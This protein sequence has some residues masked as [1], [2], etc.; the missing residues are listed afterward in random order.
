MIV[1]YT[2]LALAILASG[3][4][5]QASAAAFD[6]CP[7]EAFLVQGTSSVAYGVNL[8]TG[9]YH[10]LPEDGIVK[11]IISGAGKGNG[12]GYSFHD[13]HIYGWT[14]ADDTVFKM[15]DDYVAEPLTLKN[16]GLLST[17]FYIGDV[18]PYVQGDSPEET[19]TDNA[20]YMY[21][22]GNSH[23]LYRVEL[24]P[25]KGDDYLRITRIISGGQLNY[26][27]YDF[28][29]HPTNGFLYSVDK[30]G[31]LVKINASDGSSEVLGNVGQSG[32]F[33]A[34]YFDSDGNLYISRNQD[35]NIYRVNVTSDTPVAEFFAFGPSS[36][37]NDGARCA[38]ADVPISEDTVDEGDAPST[39]D[40]GEGGGDVGAVHGKVDGIQLG[41]TLGGP[42]D[43][44]TFITGFETGQPALVS[45][46]AQGEKTLTAWID[47]DQNGSFDDDEIVFDNLELSE[48]STTAVIDVPTDAVVG[49][50]W[51]R[52]RYSPA[53]TTSPTGGA[54]DGEV[55]DYELTVTESGVGIISYPG[56]NSFVS[57]AFEDNWPHQGDYD[58]NDV[59]MSFQTEK[60]VDATSSVVRYVMSGSLLAV[61]ASYH[62]GFAVL[63]DGIATNNIETDRVVLTINGELVDSATF[64]PLEQNAPTDDAVLIIT[65]DLWQ[66]V[67][68]DPGCSYFRTE[69]GCD[70][71]QAFTFELSVSLL[72][73]VAV[74]DAP[75]DVLNPFIFATPGQYHGD[76]LAVEGQEHPGRSL[77]IHL[78]N[79]PVS[80]Q[81]NTAFF[82]MADD[83][84]DPDNDLTF[85]TGNNMPWAL[86]LPIVWSH[87]IEKNDVMDAY[88]GFRSFVESLGSSNKTWYLYQNSET[89]RVI[90]NY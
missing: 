19:E 50:T 40:E 28:A 89:D 46:N 14:Y 39:Y 25:D 52:F 23:G 81:F 4:A 67:S 32:T 70:S 9:S 22:G 74:A 42:D 90:Q 47:W 5:T 58:M 78:K 34:V 85:M 35:G 62:S 43:G 54:E 18:S 68:A 41:D 72:N 57:L 75:A 69:D 38:K 33:G 24:D 60:Y 86:E 88:T 37:N 64:D 59:V 73:G 71:E 6:A 7:T 1:K 65:D 29:F 45:I 55:E 53:D 84:S 66:E 12:V 48:G 11:T 3:L 17:G 79:K 77:E 8:A 76:G 16:P 30:N 61:G 13:D 15:G 80:A 44:I 49:D 51:S 36:G 83:N 2:K 82:G 31:R 21:R 26:S 10:N 20:Y 87:P 27:I 56:S 63:L